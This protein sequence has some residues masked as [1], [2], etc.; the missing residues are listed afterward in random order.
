MAERLLIAILAAGASRRLGQP[1]QLVNV[2]GEPLLQRQCR[3]AIESGV[4]PVAVI[5]G[6]RAEACAAA[7]KDLQVAIRVNEHWQ[8]GVASSLRE[9]VL[10]AIEEDAVGLLILHGD[11]YRITSGDLQAMHAAWSSAGGGKACRA[12][13]ADYAGPP[14]IF[15]AMCFAELLELTGDEGARRVLSPLVGTDALIDVPMA[16]AIQ[17]LD[18][19]EQLPGLLAPNDLGLSADRVSRFG[20][21]YF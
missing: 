11:Q 1:K 4:A 17:D 21:G 8:E 20:A 6:S 9:A 10:A 15:P 3:I 19:P 13:H 18:L 14:V 7:I 12:R 16:N 5:L 2:G